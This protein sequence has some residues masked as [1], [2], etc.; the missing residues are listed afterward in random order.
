MLPATVLDPVLFETL[1]GMVAID[2]T[3]EAHL[4]QEGVC[5]PT[6]SG[7]DWCFWWLG[8]AGSPCLDF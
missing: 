2:Q 3:L 7:V 1:K 4:S 8:G 5:E 6:P